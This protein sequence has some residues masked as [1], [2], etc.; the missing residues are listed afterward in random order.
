MK[1]YVPAFSLCSF[2]DKPVEMHEVCWTMCHNDP[3]LWFD[4]K[5]LEFYR[6]LEMCLI[7]LKVNQFTI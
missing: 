2:S 4:L 7:S 3:Y 1:I 5:K 6:K